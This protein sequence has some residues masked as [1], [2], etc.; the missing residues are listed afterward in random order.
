MSYTCRHCKTC[1]YAKFYGCYYARKRVAKKDTDGC[2]CWR[3][4]PKEANK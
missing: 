4:E 2:R 1:T 3:Y